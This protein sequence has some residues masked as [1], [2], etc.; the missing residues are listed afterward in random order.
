[1]DSSARMLKL[2]SLLQARPNWTGPELAERLEVTDRTLRRDMTRLRELGYPVEAFSGPAGG[3]H[4]APGGSLPPLLFENDEAVAVALGLRS[5]AS[6]GLPGFEDA[7]V[8]ALSKITQVLPLKLASQVDNL[9][10]ATV[11]LAWRSET[12]AAVDPSALTVLAQACRI[13]ERVRFRYTD[14]EGRASERHVEPFQ[15]VRTSRRWYLVALDRDREAWRTFRVDR[16]QKPV[17]TGMRFI[18]RETPDAA[19]L[20]A[21]GVAVSAHTLQARVLLRIP[22]PKAKDMIHP[23]IGIVSRAE[24]GGTLLRIGADDA[25]WVARYLANLPCDFEVLEPEEIVAAV[26]ELGRKLL[27]RS[28][29][30]GGSGGNSAEEGRR[31]DGDA[32]R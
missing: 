4:L 1:M 26:R 11:G 28:T 21:E 14:S 7:A 20:V 6:G 9:D 23:T 29:M 16:I 3:Y 32:K 19:A 12:G 22:L 13:P 30:L 17:R 24:G 2:L 25:G 5:A 15:L 18:H 8:S 10:R 31:N 27:D